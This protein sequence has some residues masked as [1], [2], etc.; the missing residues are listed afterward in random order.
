MLYTQKVKRKKA[1]P[2]TIEAHQPKRKS[3][4]EERSKEILQ[5]QLENKFFKWQ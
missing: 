4:R 3:T 5:K 1:K 2:N